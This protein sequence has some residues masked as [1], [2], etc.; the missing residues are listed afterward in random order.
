MAYKYDHLA[1]HGFKMQGSS[2]S[3]FT[4]LQNIVLLLSE[5][6]K[7]IMKTE[8]F[9]GAIAISMLC[10]QSWAL[11]FRSWHSVSDCVLPINGDKRKI[12]R[13]CFFPLWLTWLTWLGFFFQ[14]TA[15]DQTLWRSFAYHHFSHASK[16]GCYLYSWGG[17]NVISFD[18]TSFFDESKD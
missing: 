1:E 18:F 13:P 10:F 7:H 8:I 12:L 4:N 15:G 17:K 16:K 3:S 9:F 6:G 14:V 11:G 2:W 5:L